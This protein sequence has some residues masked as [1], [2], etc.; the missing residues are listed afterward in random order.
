M[1]GKR[2]TR[3]P[4]AARAKRRCWRAHLVVREEEDVVSAGRC[5]PKRQGGAQLRR[6]TASQ[7]RI[8]L[9]KLARVSGVPRAW[10][11]AACA[12]RAAVTGR[13]G[14]PRMYFAGPTESYTGS[15]RHER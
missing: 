5:I 11:S 8:S 1:D 9:V 7:A 12:A 13:I 2:E 6:R 4:M 10:S 3:A 15:M 14:K